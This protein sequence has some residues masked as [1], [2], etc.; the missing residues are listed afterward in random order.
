MTLKLLD[1]EKAAFP[2]H[3]DVGQDEIGSSLMPEANGLLSV[4]SLAHIISRAAQ[5]DLQGP[6]NIGL[7]IHYQDQPLRPLRYLEVRGRHPLDSY[8][9]FDP[10]I[11]RRDRHVGV[12]AFDYPEPLPEV[13][14]R[15]PTAMLGA[16]SGSALRLV[17]RRA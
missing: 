13:A 14:E 2:G 8:R 4:L 1:E 16:D 11:A 5:R 15:V 17:S 9:H 10:Y 3:V 6:P 7:V 12:V